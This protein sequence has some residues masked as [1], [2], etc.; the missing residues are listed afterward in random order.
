MDFHDHRHLFVQF[1]E[2]QTSE[3]HEYWIL[4]KI[5]PSFT[6]GHEGWK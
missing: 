2:L 3:N 4:L 1:E 6:V 5:F